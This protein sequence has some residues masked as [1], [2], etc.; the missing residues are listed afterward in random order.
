MLCSTSLCFVPSGPFCLMTCIYLKM[1]HVYRIHVLQKLISN[2]YGQLQ[3]TYRPEEGPSEE[4]IIASDEHEPQASDDAVVPNV[5]IITPTPPPPQH[6]LE[7]GDLLV[8]HYVLSSVTSM[9][10]AAV[11]IQFHISYNI[12][13]QKKKIFLFC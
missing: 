7:T 9:Y 11:S 13:P 1:E 6:N 12:P 2:P 5:E 8:N 3:L 4:T 10:I